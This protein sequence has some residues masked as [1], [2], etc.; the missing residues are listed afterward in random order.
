MNRYR[1]T[2]P[3]LLMF[4]GMTAHANQDCYEMDMVL[5]AQLQALAE[6]AF[7]YAGD[8]VKNNRLNAEIK[9]FLK[10]NANSDTWKCTFPLARRELNIVTSKDEKLRA[11]AWDNQQGGTMRFSYG[12]WQYRD[13][14]G[15]TH[16]MDAHPEAEE[17]E[18]WG[19]SGFV[20]AIYT[21]RLGKKG[22]AYWLI[23]LHQGSTLLAGHKA[24]L[25]HVLKDKL[26]YADLIALNG[27]YGHELRFEIDDSG[28]RKDSAFDNRIP[29]FIYDNKRKEMR[30]SFIDYEDSKYPDGKVVEDAAIWR[31]NGQYFVPH[32][33]KSPTRRGFSIIPVP[34]GAA[35][36]W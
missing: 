7:P 21:A 14:A 28:M 30:I 20:R 10:A 2:L 8:G 29:E 16:I 1:H 32:K 9:N 17:P 11:Y 12:L 24:T 4:V 33:M 27:G 34:G 6:V 22:T 26:A 25:L 31:F 35:S 23:E 15:K 19:N 3:A 5:K 13:K 36:G 18:R